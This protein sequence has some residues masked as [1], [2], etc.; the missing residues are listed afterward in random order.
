MATTTR[1]SERGQVVIPKPIRDELRL[2]RGQELDVDVQNGEI[3][4][5]LRKKRGKVR[6]T[7]WRRWRGVLAGTGALQDLE[8]EHRREIESG[9]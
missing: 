5:R 6:T 8:A 3:R 7:D 4:M 1:L 9:R 2:K